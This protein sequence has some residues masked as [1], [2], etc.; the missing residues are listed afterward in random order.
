MLTS[1]R[2]PMRHND[3]A[4]VAVTTQDAWHIVG[5]YVFYSPSHLN[6]HLNSAVYT[7]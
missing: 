3:G 4:R 1:D 7:T 6:L 2:L 5:T